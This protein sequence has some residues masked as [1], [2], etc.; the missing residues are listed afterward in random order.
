MNLKYPIVPRFHFILFPILFVL[1]YISVKICFI[2]HHQL[3][4]NLK[5]FII[6]VLFM[7]HTP[8]FWMLSIRIRSSHTWILINNINP[9]GR[10]FED[11]ITH[12]HTFL[13]LIFLYSCL[14]GYQLSL[15]FLL[16]GCLPCSFTDYISHSSCYLKFL[17][18][19]I[20]V[21]FSSKELV[22]VNIWTFLYLLIVL[23]C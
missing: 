10:L 9:L 12:V 23:H 15:S 6:I 22:H 16:S 13:L 17:V 18:L 4:V 7:T 5:D 1:Y 19:F 21:N 3:I 14:V 11:L 8:C 20:S 2:F